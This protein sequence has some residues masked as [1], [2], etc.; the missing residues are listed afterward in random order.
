MPVLDINMEAAHSARQ[1]RLASLRQA[2]EELASGSTTSSSNSAKPIHPFR[3]A[4]LLTPSLRKQGDPSTASTTTDAAQDLA[5]STVEGQL[6]RRF[7]N[8]DPMTG[9][10]RDG[11]WNTIQ[12]IE[13]EVKDV[14]AEALRQ[15]EENRLKELDLKNL[16]PRKQNWDLRNHWEKRLKKLSRKDKEARLVLIRE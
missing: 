9:Q 14:Q 16:A 3:R 4:F 10:P 7:R 15:D 1:A 13:D 11:L 12:G 6:L 8:W 5:A 2:K